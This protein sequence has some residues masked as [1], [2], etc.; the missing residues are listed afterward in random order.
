MITISG[1][2]HCLVRITAA[3]REKLER[4]IFQRYP[5][6]EWGTF[7]R[8]GY[9]RTSWGLAVSF[10]DALPPRPGD[11]DRRSGI[12]EFRSGYI[13]HA[14]LEVEQG[15]LGIGVVHSHPQGCAVHPSKLD[16]DMDA[17]FGEEFPAYSKQA[18]YVSLIFSRGRD[19]KCRFS[20][21]V[22][23]G[24]K[25]LLATELLTVGIE[26]QREQS[27]LKT[28]VPSLNGKMFTT[29]DGARESINCRLEQLVGKDGAMKLASAKVA[30]IGCSG[31]ASPMAHALV[32]AGVRKFVLI[33]PQ[34]FS[35]SNL[36]RLH[37]STAD[38]LNEEPLPFKVS[39]VRRL[40]N[41][42]APDAHV[43]ALVGNALDEEVLDEL[44]TCDLV[45]GC[46]DTQHGRAFLG[47]LASHY[48]LP[49]IDVGVRMRAKNG[50]LTEQVA[51]IVA[52]E[53]RQPCPFCQRRINQNALTDELV[54]DQERNRRQTAA[55]E[56]EAKGLDGKQYWG[57]QIPQELTVGYQTATVANIAAGYAIGWA[58]GASAMPHRRFQF[59]PAMPF[60]GVVPADGAHQPD[61]TCL[62][63]TGF[64][65]QARADRSV[66]R[67][68]H[69]SSAR[70]LE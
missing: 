16:D 67:P 14:Q 40:I 5:N 41:D 12:V 17:Y 32:R 47:D 37:G 15:A 57:G 68:S 23:D 64:A 70:V 6:K 9:R 63:T 62:Q 52:Y 55:A 28:I 19:G 4:L 59:D 48:L 22:N 36:E 42:I 29:K 50:K 30:I 49:S 61:C 46:T 53:P 1:N 51:E 13:L 7:F 3:D 38:D 45:L 2:R 27:S 26:L 33:D 18:P 24:G 54:T 21:R 10:V 43:T 35:P 69:W 20:G 39:I 31:T 11:L 66:S 58:T 44:L 60:L 25:W 34:R 8:F 56:A 65:D